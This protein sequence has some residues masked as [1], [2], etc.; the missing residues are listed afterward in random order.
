MKTNVKKQIKEL[1]D[2]GVYGYHDIFN[3]LY[4]T[5]MGHYN[6]LRNA[7]AEVKNG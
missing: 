4:P 6:T 7:I 1:I 3:R 2:Q 5:Y